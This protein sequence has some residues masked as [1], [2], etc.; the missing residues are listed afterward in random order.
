MATQGVQIPAADG[1]RQAVLR[2]QRSV[3]RLMQAELRALTGGDTP[4]MERYER[5]YLRA[6]NIPW[7]ASAS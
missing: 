2:L 3:Q 1:V 4:A 5:E 6:A 7:R